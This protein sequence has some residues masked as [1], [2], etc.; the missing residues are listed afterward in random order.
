MEKKKKKIKK[1]ATC[2]PAAAGKNALR[3]EK[4]IIHVPFFENQAKIGC[5][6]MPKACTPVFLRHEKP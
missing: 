2:R 3:E 5:K 4:G 1:I 6:V